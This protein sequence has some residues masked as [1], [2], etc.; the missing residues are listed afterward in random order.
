MFLWSYW[1][2]IPY[3]RTLLLQCGVSSVLCCCR[4]CQITVPC[5]C[6]CHTHVVA[7][8]VGSLC[9]VSVGTMHVCCCMVCRIA[10]P[11]QCGYHVAWCAGSLCHV[12][13]GTI[14][15]CCCMVFRITV[16][17]QC[18][19]MCA[20][21]QGVL[22]VWVPYTCTLLQGVSDHC[23]MSVWVPY[24]C[25][26]QL[27]GALRQHQDDHTNVTVSCFQHSANPLN[28]TKTVCLCSVCTS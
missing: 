24:T 10:V 11:C 8:C 7:G 14:H 19:Y 12:S 22:S 5:Q 2:T 1:S 15:M 3:R 18:G 20:V 21:L 23:P 6:G 28:G 26:D 16:L 27:L 4:V 25:A 17:C 9:H 13:V